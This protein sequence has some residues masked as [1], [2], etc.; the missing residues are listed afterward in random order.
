MVISVDKFI[1]VNIMVV[2]ELRHMQLVFFAATYLSNKN[3][4]MCLSI[5]S[6]SGW[7][8][9]CV[10]TEWL[11][12][13]ES[14]ILTINQIYCHCLA[15]TKGEIMQIKLLNEVKKKLKLNDELLRRLLII[16]FSGKFRNTN[17]VFNFSLYFT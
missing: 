12:V 8:V 3:N 10:V 6:E 1:Y 13:N 9:S 17:K 4:I 11:A 14:L 2:T 15:R 7:Y 5:K 16:R